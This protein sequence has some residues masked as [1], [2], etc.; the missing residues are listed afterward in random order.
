MTTQGQRFNGGTHGNLNTNKDSL[1]YDHTRVKLSKPVNGTD[2]INAT[3]IKTI[4]GE[5]AYD[6]LVYQDFLPYSKIRIILSQTPTNDSQPHY[7]KM[8]QDNQIDVVF[9]VASNKP[10]LDW[11]NVSYGNISKELTRWYDLNDTLVKQ[12]IAIRIK[13][14]RTHYATILTFYGWLEDNEFDAED[15]ET[16]KTFLTAMTHLR[17]EIGKKND[18]F[19]ILAHDER[20]G[21]DGASALIVLL[22][23]LEEIDFGLRGKRQRTGIDLEAINVFEAIKELRKKRAYMVRSFAT[24]EFLFNTMAFYASNK[25]LFDEMLKKINA[26]DRRQ[27]AAGRRKTSAIPT[28]R[29]TEKTAEEEIFG[30]SDSADD[31]DF[32][33]NSYRPSPVTYVYDDV[34]PIMR[35]TSVTYVYDENK[36]GDRTSLIN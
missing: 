32:E 10:P 11:K 28:N 33:P 24:Y 3:W 17:N 8:I 26:K 31:T 36:E 7:L 13:E 27:K 29:L 23:L 15:M 9:Q 22:R 12:H 6:E 30:Y 2:Y 16:A 25:T 19:T 18:T 14:E 20:G 4:S 21:I 34:P 5:D 1:P 35:S